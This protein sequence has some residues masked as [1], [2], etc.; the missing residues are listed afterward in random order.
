MSPRLLNHL[1]DASVAV[2]GLAAFTGLIGLLGIVTYGREGPD[3]PTKTA[4]LLVAG[5]VVWGLFLYAS[6]RLRKAAQT[7]S[8]ASHVPTPGLTARREVVREFLGAGALI[9]AAGVVAPFILSAV[10]GIPG[11][12]AGVILM[13]VLLSVGYSKARRYY[14]SHCKNSIADSDVHVCPTCSAQLQ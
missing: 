14:C 6:I 7:A 5:T 4:L 9:Q 10:A 11:A 13:V 1:S 8:A 12:I 2:A 3:F